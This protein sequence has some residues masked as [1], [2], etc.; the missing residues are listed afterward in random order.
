MKKGKFESGKS[1]AFGKKSLVLVLALA[2]LLGG[3]IGGTIAWLTST[4]T[5]ITNTFSTSNVSVTLTED[6]KTFKMIPGHP[7]TKDPQIKVA[8]NSEDCY[9]FIEITKD[10]NLDNYIKYQ[11]DTTK[12][13][14]VPGKTDVYYLKVGTGFN[15][16]DTAISVLGEGS[17][18]IDGHTYSWAADQV[19]TLP[20]VTESMM[21]TAE[22]SAPELTFTVYAIQLSMDG[23]TAFEPDA[24]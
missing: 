22:T 17:E 14:L 24:A 5:T 1:F 6:A 7:M 18:T 16:K 19:L 20:S 13:T 2:L 21:D 4:T 23:T 15:A 12:W 10:N 11:V 9:V 8:A 3:V